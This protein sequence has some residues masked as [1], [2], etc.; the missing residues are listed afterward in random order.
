MENLF[1]QSGNNPN[2]MPSINRDNLYLHI[3]TTLL[4]PSLGLSSKS[5]GQ[6]LQHVAQL[7]HATRLMMTKGMLQF[8]SR[9]VLQDTITSL[10]EFSSFLWIFL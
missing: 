2:R 7:V 10:I 8:T 1:T 4:N 9:E 5:S 6:V 3:S